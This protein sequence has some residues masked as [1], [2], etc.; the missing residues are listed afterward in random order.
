MSPKRISRGRKI[1]RAISESIA[2]L[3]KGK[4]A[5]EAEPET[6]AEAKGLVG[7]DEGTSRRAL[8]YQPHRA[9]GSSFLDTRRQAYG[10]EPSGALRAIG[11]PRSRVKRLREE[12][13]NKNKADQ[14]NKS[15]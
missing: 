13:A 8:R 10:V 5:A 9:A 11:K 14:G 7:E 6:E 3:T 12:R 1:R 4:P 2:R 15:A